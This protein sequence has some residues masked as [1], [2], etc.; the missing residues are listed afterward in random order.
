MVLEEGTGRL[1]IFG[2]VI[3]MI[4]FSVWLLLLWK[5]RRNKG[6]IWFIPQ[7]GMLILAF[8]MLRRL[9]NNYQ[10]VPSTMLSEENTLTLG[11]MGL[12]FAASLIFMLVGI[13]KTSN[14]N[15]RKGK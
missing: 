9:I 15:L 3:L 10:T 13:G 6:F 5:R 14:I 2:F 11:F 12:S 4:I 8:S 1:V 7:G